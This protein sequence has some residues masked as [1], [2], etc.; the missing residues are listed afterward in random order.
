M[1]ASFAGLHGVCYS[2]RVRILQSVYPLSTVVYDPLLPVDIEL[3]L[4]HG[5]QE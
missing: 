4:V 5:Y 1:V 3:F 2:H